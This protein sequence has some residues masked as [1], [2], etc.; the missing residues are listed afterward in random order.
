MSSSIKQR[1]H[2]FLR[3]GRC[4]W[5]AMIAWRVY[6]SYFLEWFG[7]MNC[8]REIKTCWPI[9]DLCGLNDFVRFDILNHKDVV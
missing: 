8:D 3:S 2:R 5:S 1:M 6:V 9:Q 7:D 4:S